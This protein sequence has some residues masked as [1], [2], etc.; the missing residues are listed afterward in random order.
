MKHR[1]PF[2]ISSGRVQDDH[3]E[4]FRARQYDAHFA[5]EAGSVISPL[6][7]VSNRKR[8]HWVSVACLFVCAGLLLRLTQVQLL[9]GW[10]HRAS[11]EENR[12]S[13]KEIDAPRGLIYDRN[14]EMLVRNVP[15]FSI[16]V[17]PS[18]LP[19]SADALDAL[20]QTLSSELEMP[21]QDI[22]ARIEQGS[23]DYFEPIV[24]KE[25][26]EYTE[27]VRHYVRLRNLSSV[28]L[29]VQARRDYVGGPTFSAMLGYMGKFSSRE[30]YASYK[31]Q[32]Y[33]FGDRIGKTGLELYYEDA[34]RGKKGK[35]RIEV[36]VYNNEQK[37][38]AQTEALAGSHLVLGI[39]ASLQRVLQASLDK[40]IS[41]NGNVGGAAVAIDPRNGELRAVV[42]S[43][44]YDNNAF[45]NGIDAATYAKLRDDPRKPLFA[46]AWSGTFPSGS[47]IKPFW[48]AAGLAEG[49][50]NRSTTVLSTGAIFVGPWRFPDWK[51]GG[52][53]RVNVVEAIGWSVN[54]FFYALGG[55]YEQV[56]GVGVEL[57]KHYGELFGFNSTT[58][59]DLPG[60]ASGFLP[61]PE[62]KKNTKGEP[63]YIGDTYLMSIGQGDVLVTPLQMAVATAAIANGGTY[64]KPHVVS[65]IKTGDDEHPVE[66][67]VVRQHIVDPAHVEIVREGMRYTVTNGSAKRMQELSIP[68]AAKTGTAQFDSSDDTHAWFTAFAPYD[69]PELVIA[70]IIEKGGQ[71]ST[72]ALPVA[73]DAFRQ[74]FDLPGPEIR[75]DATAE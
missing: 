35:Q 5:D 39:D 9:E 28:Q 16:Y 54:T 59:V 48:A 37:L 34:L 10:V 66:P 6:Q 13:I 64:Y 60:E 22:T 58:G 18:E 67:T 62:W 55:G 19:E 42:S 11:A 3:L 20:V 8:L 2:S 51:V 63:W 33:S 46:R 31:D 56:R 24:L 1:D 65:S 17:I 70:I 72:T 23:R 41:E 49:T 32:G 29:L 50:I 75:H 38:I 52:H 30:D 4:G 25:G 45:A 73:Q 53:G 71:G 36:D 15:T 21:A 27:A 61:D 43:P 47:T 74:Y 26:L 7:Y 57:L 14:G 44:S 69:H 68:T 12:I 40:A